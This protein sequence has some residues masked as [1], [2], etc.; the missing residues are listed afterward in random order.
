[1]RADRSDPLTL[2]A[3]FSGLLR[4]HDLFF[5]PREGPPRFPLVLDPALLRLLCESLS[6]S[7]S[8][9]TSCLVM[10]FNT[11]TKGI[12]QL[13]ILG[14]FPTIY[15]FLSPPPPKPPPFLIL[16]FLPVSPLFLS[17]ASIFSF[18]VLARSR[19]TLTVP[20]ETKLGAY[21]LSPLA[22]RCHLSSPAPGLSP[23]SPPSEL[24]FQG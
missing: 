1:V 10:T 6:C 4:I 8:D 7:G 22:G 24:K 23:P 16:P 2:F 13:K 17:Q 12:R 20:T 11:L 9:S 5:S 18:L 14:T 3:F 21:R 15:L 19:E